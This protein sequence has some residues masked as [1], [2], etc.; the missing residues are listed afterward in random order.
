MAAITRRI[1]EAVALADELMSATNEQRSGVRLGRAEQPRFAAA[2]II[3]AET[4]ESSRK[5]VAEPWL[6]YRGSRN[7]VQRQE[8]TNL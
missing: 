8:W 4:S 3:L 5:P 7:R 2:V 6:R 1:D